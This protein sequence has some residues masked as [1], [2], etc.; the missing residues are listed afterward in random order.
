MTPETIILKSIYSLVGV[1]GFLDG[2]F[3]LCARFLPYAATLVFLG[4]LL[5]HREPYERLVKIFYSTF[6]LVLS[7][8]L[9][10]GIL[11]FVVTRVNPAKALGFHA[12][13]GGG[14]FPAF[15][16]TWAVAV[17]C[18]CY[19]ALSRR[20]GFWL[21]LVAII[22]GFAQ[23]Y[24]GLAW[25]LDI[26]VSVAIGITGPLFALRFIPPSRS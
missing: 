25:P 8:G 12:L 26:L 4:N 20:I 19:L 15:A 6:A 1:S 13:V 3:V 16:T 14:G 7:A 24:V 11:D 22:V 9:F 10:Q 17:A 5:V 21:F 2:L 18:I 23:M